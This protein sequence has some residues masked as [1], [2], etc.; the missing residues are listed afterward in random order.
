[1]CDY[2]AVMALNT[3]DSGGANYADTSKAA[4]VAVPLAAFAATND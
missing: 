1:M 2:A 4:T 3:T